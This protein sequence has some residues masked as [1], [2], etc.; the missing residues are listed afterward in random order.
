VIGQSWPPLTA[1][2]KRPKPTRRT[3]RRVAEKGALCL[4]IKAKGRAQRQRLGLRNREAALRLTTYVGPQ[5]KAAFLGKFRSVE[6]QAS[7]TAAPVDGQ[8]ER[9]E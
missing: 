9:S 5:S 3:K 1:S 4:A 8:K 7:G 6:I 2:K